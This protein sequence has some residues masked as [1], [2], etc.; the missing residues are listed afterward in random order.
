MLWRPD[1]APACGQVGP[2]TTSGEP[3]PVQAVSTPTDPVRS[4]VQ[5]WVCGLQRN[6]GTHRSH[7]HSGS[8]PTHAE[9]D[10]SGPDIHYGADGTRDT[11]WQ[12]PQDQADG[13]GSESPSVYSLNE[14]IQCVE[15]FFS[16]LT[17]ITRPAAPKPPPLLLPPFLY[18]F[19]T[20]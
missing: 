16:S 1:S 17:T 10:P 8:L 6:A 19:P 3:S 14:P 18:H 7:L 11:G 9:R 20:L 5:G 13:R 15:S 2:E 12:E 4:V